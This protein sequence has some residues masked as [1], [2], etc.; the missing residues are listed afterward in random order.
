M[1]APGS[2]EDL[3]V[4][5]EDLW[6]DANGM[7]NHNSSPEFQNSDLYNIYREKPTASTWVHPKGKWVEL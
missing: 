5:G 6:M 4:L 3:D 7:M 1:A 2:S